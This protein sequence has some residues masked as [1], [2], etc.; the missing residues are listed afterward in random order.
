VSVDVEADA[1]KVGWRGSWQEGKQHQ[2]Q[3]RYNAPAI[4]TWKPPSFLY[5]ILKPVGMKL[6]RGNVQA[7]EELR[8]KGTRS[9]SLVWGVNM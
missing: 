2:R 3:G 8:M 1:R 4:N 9:Q 5:P 7:D 6:S